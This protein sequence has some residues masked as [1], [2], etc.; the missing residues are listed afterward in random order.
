VK[1]STKAALISA[2][3]FPGLGHIYLKKY[4]VGILLAGFSAASIYYMVSNVMEI[5]MEISGKIESGAISPDIATITALVSQQAN[6][7]NTQ[8]AN[9]ATSVFFICWSIAIIDSYR[10]GIAQEKRSELV[11][12]N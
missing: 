6:S 12:D 9:I 5:A 1:K 8:L 2:F 3:V 10:L 11:L 4:L 7:A